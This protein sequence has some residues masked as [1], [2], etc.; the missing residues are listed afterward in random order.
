L[1]SRSDSIWQRLAWLVDDGGTPVVKPNAENPATGKSVSHF[2][3]VGTSLTTSTVP[4]L[5]FIDNLDKLVNRDF[6]AHN[7][8]ALIQHASI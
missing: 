5:L 4:V 7:L 2:R 3:C 6:V 8:A 1:G